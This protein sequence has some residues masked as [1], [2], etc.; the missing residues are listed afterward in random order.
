MFSRT[1]NALFFLLHNLLYHRFWVTNFCSSTPQISKQ[2]M[3]RGKYRILLR[4][5]RK[6]SEQVMEIHKPQA[7]LS[8]SKPPTNIFRVYCY[9]IIPN[10]TKT[11]VSFKRI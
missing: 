1:K 9:K 8:I 10:Q 5:L 3:L 11:R 2:K 4:S 7:I 6:Y